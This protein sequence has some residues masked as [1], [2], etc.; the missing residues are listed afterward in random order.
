VPANALAL[1]ASS[2]V[3]AAAVATRSLGIQ[4]FI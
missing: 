1:I 3:T 4:P 2:A